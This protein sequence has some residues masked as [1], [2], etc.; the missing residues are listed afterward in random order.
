MIV[1]VKD[2]P[3]SGGIASPLGPGPKKV[4][5]SHAKVQKP[6]TAQQSNQ[7]IDRA[8]INRIAQDDARIL[9][10]GRLLMDAIPDVRSAKI[11]TAQHRMRTGYYEKPEVRA[12]IFRNMVEDPESYPTIPPMTEKD[13]ELVF[14]RLKRNFYEEPEVKNQIAKGMIDDAVEGE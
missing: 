2:V 3:F 12:Q 8:E 13:I 14:E 11:E 9:K 5:P 7:I 1:Y 6:D 10:A 4:E